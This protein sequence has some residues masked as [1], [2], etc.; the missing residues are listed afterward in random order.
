MNCKTCVIV[1]NGGILANKSLGQRIDEFDVVVRY[2]MTQR[3]K[4]FSLFFKEATFWQL[5]ILF[6]VCLCETIHLY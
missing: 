2:V 3:D 5:S 6:S 1:G 4:L